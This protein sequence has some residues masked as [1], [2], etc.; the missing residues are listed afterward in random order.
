MIDIKR[1]EDCVGCGACIDI[2]NKNAIEFITDIE[3]FWYPKVDTNK[4]VNCGMCE[5]VCPI[6]NSKKINSTNTDKPIAYAAYNLNREIQFESTTGGLFS[7]L[8]QKMLDQGGYIAGAIWT[9]NHMVEHIVSNK[10]DDLNLIRGSKYLQS[11]TTGLYKKISKLLSLG[12]NVLVCGCPCQMAALRSF[13]KYKNFDNLIIVDFICCSI[14]SPKLFRK[15]LDSLENEYGSKILKY[16]PKNKEYGG[17]HNFAFKATFENG[18]IYVKNTI[19]DDFTRCFIGTH[20]AGRP[21]CYECK[22]KMIPRVADITIADFWGIENV[23]PVMDNKY[24][25]SLVIANNTK[26]RNFFFS[27]RDVI[28]EKEESL[29]KAT[30]FNQHLIKSLSPSLINRKK[31][32]LSLDRNGFRYVMDKYGY[33]NNKWYKKIISKITNRF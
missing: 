16:H 18:N 29:E 6:I 28:C 1:K 25:T 5:A 32:Y 21:C 8:A 30:A 19:D 4:C 23:D 3:G 10:H 31:F 15:Y 13:L 17:W 11:N 27:I 9:K 33:I 2:C 14:N 7:A 26:G 22:F 12:E 24:G 20:I